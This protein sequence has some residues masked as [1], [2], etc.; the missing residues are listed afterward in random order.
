MNKIPGLRTLVSPDLC[1]VPVG[2]SLEKEK[3]GGKEVGVDI[4]VLSSLMEKRGWN[5]FTSADPDCLAM[6][7]GQQHAARDAALI[8]TWLRDLE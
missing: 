7:L 1:I 2:A 3:R 8:K 4:F 5:L 6:C